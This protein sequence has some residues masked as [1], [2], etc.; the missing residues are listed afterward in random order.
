MGCQ[1]LSSITVGTFWRTL[2]LKEIFKIAKKA[3]YSSLIILYWKN[4]K[5]VFWN[6]ENVTLSL[7][8]QAWVLPQRV[9]IMHH[10]YLFKEGIRKRYE[11][12]VFFKASKYIRIITYRVLF[13]IRTNSFRKY[14]FLC[15]MCKNCNVLSG[16]HKSFVRIG[17]EISPKIFIH[18]S[19][20]CRTIII[21]FSP[22]KTAYTQLDVF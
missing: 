11:K 7:F 5:H 3:A 13:N 15:K 16:Y 14:V 9:A 2:L 1:N 21:Y 10:F 4:P 18:V 20:V 6:A 22:F 12:Y 19:R 8:S 17:S